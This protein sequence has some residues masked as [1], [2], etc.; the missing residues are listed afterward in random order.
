MSIYTEMI[1]KIK[2]AKSE[3]AG[4]GVLVSAFS[5]A[6]SGGRDQLAR[7]VLDGSAEVMKALK[8]LPA[9]TPAK[10]VEKPVANPTNFNQPTE[11]PFT[12]FNPTPKK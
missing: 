5:G 4:L 3:R 12:G 2:D 6:D 10:P 7:D 9:K 1:A 11:K 8:S